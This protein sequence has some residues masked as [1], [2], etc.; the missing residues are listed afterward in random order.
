M[1]DNYDYYVYTQL[2]AAL[3]WGKTNP[4][5]A[6]S[7]IEG[8]LTN[9][10]QPTPP[11]TVHC[12][13]ENSWGD[14]IPPEVVACRKAGHPLVRVDGRGC[15]TVTECPICGVCYKTDSSD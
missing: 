1:A 11:K 3:S 15:V 9:L 2:Q 4:Q 5:Y 7:L 13:W 10:P 8:V 12:G 14:D 6:M